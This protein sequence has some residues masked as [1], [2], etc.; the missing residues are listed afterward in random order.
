MTAI[1]TMPIIENI[2]AIAALPPLD[3]PPDD[4]VVFA[5]ILG[6]LII[7]PGLGMT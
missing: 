2:T 5:V 1:M 7:T 4:S 6:S 3:R